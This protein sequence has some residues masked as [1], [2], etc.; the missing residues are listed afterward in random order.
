[1]LAAIS[2]INRFSRGCAILTSPHDSVRSVLLYVHRD[3][4][5]YLLGTGVHDV[6]L[7]YHTAPEPL[8]HDGVLAAILLTSLLLVGAVFN[9]ST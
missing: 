6:L 3:R 8:L 7:F 9:P 4:A 5:E 1:M 2:S